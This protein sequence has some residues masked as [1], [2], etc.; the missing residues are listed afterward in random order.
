MT[1]KRLPTA[2]MLVVLTWTASV[3]ADAIDDY[4]ARAMKQFHLPG[5]ALLVVRDGRVVKAAG[6]GFADI[7]RKIPATPET[8]FKIGSISKQLIATGIMLLVQDGRLAADDPVTKYFPDAPPSWAPMRVRHL[9]SHTAGLVRESPTF[10][11]MKATSDADIVRGL[12]SLPLR[13][14]P[15]SKWEYSNAGYYALAE[16]IRVVSGRPWTEF[17]HGRVLAPLGMNATAPTNVRPKPSAMATGY[18]GTDN[19]GGPAPEWMALRPS[20]AFLSTVLD[21]A[22][23]DAA[24]SAN[25]IL[26][27]ASRRQMWSR[28]PLH[29]G[30]S[31]PYGFGW[32]IG[33]FQNRR[34][35]RHGGGLPG[36][37]SFSMRFLDVPLSIV[38]L[39]NGDDVDPAGI[40]ANV[41]LIQ[42]REIGGG[43]DRVPSVSHAG[44]RE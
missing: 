34:V 43:R 7:E 4:I 29:D 15:G 39:T 21:L 44:S 5:V 42:L 28:A 18:A 8:V 17:I 12:Y 2:V 25:T 31:A 36:F 16:M 27:E 19:A 35:I 9:L 23:W 38:V 33:E 24:L 26:S 37:S 14:E 13:F 1:L 10:D 6:Y 41:A 30:G 20:G 40:V 3:R 22:K 32:H 11:P